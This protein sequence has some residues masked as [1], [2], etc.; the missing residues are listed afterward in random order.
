MK[1]VLNGHTKPLSVFWQFSFPLQSELL[2]FP[3]IFEAASTH[4]SRDVLG[5]LLSP[6]LHLFSFLYF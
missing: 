5:G 4:S 3:K 2:L 1:N 6:T